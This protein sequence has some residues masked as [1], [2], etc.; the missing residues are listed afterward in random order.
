[1][2][3]VTIPDSVTS[4]GA[5]AFLDC[6]NLLYI[7]C[8]AVSKPSEWSSYWNVC[9]EDGMYI[10]YLYHYVIWDYKNSVSSVT[11]ID[12][13]LYEII[14]DSASVIRGKKNIS[15][16][17]IPDYITIDGTPYPVTAI[18]DYAF[19]DCT[20]LTSITIGNS[21][22]SIGDYAF[23]GCSSLTN[24]TI[25]ISVTYIGNYAFAYC[26]NLTLFCESTGK[27]SGWNSNW[28]YSNCPVVW[29]Y[30]GEEYTYNFVTNGAD[31]IEP[32]TS[33]VTIVLP[34]PVREGY[35]FMGWYN[36]AEFSGNPVSDP[37]YSAT[38]HTLY[39]KWL[40]EEEYNALRD[41]SSFEKAYEITDGQTLDVVIDNAGEY[42]YF[43]F[44]AMESR[45]YTFQSNGNYDTYG[46]LYNSNQTQL[47]A[48]D[49][50]GSGN[51][52]L[53]SR[54]IYS[55]ETVYIA[56]RMYS[57]SSTGTFTVSVS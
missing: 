29:G 54:T 28:N 39:A 46:Y 4:I 18:S 40:T 57:S 36:N 21:V 3:S 31:F 6:S 38:A 11:M 16:I 33:S 53:I 49:D 56:V 7:G 25:P 26:Y 17:I 23:Y 19:C 55:G 14:I 12:G 22:T 20:S 24:V 27:P 34:T 8:E 51:N 9:Y 30:T 42:V 52:F 2:T 50:D 13:I 41:G 1:M 45:T 15:T 35:Y 10:P 44:T 32:I 5:R 37:Y 48:N 47:S 43:V